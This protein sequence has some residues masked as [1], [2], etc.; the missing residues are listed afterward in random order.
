[1]KFLTIFFSTS[2]LISSVIYGLIIA[3]DPYNKL[4]NNLF[5]FETKAVDFAREN[6]F[7]QVEHGTKKYDVFLLGSSS[8][9]RYLTKEI[10]RLTGLISYNYSTQSAT[11]ED[12]LSMTR[13]IF[14]K[15]KPKLILI[16]FQ[17]ETF[18]RFVK[19][20]DMFYSSPLQDYLNELPESEKEVSTFN[21]AYLT[22]DAIAD[23]F[24]VIWVNLFGK[25]AHTYLE[26]GDHMVEPV[27]KEVLI[28]Q[29][30][31]EEYEF[32]FKRFEYLKTLKD[33]CDKE[34]TKIIAFTN[35]LSIEHLKKIEQSPVL[36]RQQDELRATLIDIFGEI[37]DFYSPAV[38]RFNTT[39]FFRDSNHPTHEF[40]T[41][42][43]ERMLGT[44]GEDQIDLAVR[45]KK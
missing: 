30:P 20:D 12:Y 26:D 2:L 40:S 21:N 43:L 5:G 34:G 3:V 14:S 17:F 41:M 9:H 4:G 38:A 13:H 6:K 27:N 33:L 16:A 10:N 24:N 23:T 7:N 1:M 42:I 25:P 32:D 36:K 39:Q 19:T 22:L 15:Y 28:T 31:A 11:P 37:W 18:N 45:L 35:P 8:A 29:F 44:K